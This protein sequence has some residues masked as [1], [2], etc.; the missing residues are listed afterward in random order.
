[1]HIYDA[2][3]CKAWFSLSECS[4][5][6]KMGAPISTH[7]RAPTHLG[8]VGRAPANQTVDVPDKLSVRELF[9]KASI[10]PHSRL[11]GEAKRLLLLVALYRARYPLTAK[12]LAERT[13]LPDRTVRYYLL[14][15]RKSGMVVAYGSPS[16]P[17]R[18]KCP[19]TVYAL[20]RAGRLA[21]RRAI[22]LGAGSLPSGSEVGGGGWR[23]VGD[24]GS[25]SGGGRVW[26]VWDGMGDWWGEVGVRFD[27]GWLRGVLCGLLGVVGGGRPRR[28]VVYLGGDGLLHVD[29][30]SRLVDGEV[31]PVESVVWEWLVG[32]FALT[33]LLKGLFGGARLVDLVVGAPSVVVE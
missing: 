15:M 17:A 9:A 22:A 29:A 23:G 7:M 18:P 20:T 24:G 8:V 26:V 2:L 19:Y 3:G 4:N 33:C 30:V 5:K 25:G 31:P 32:W 21:A 28:L 13:G 10:R 11:S 27:W 16:H 12:Q 6:L 1:M 14:Q